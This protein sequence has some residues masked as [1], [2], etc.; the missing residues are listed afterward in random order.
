MPA[1]AGGTAGPFGVAGRLAVSLDFSASF[2]C[3]SS[4]FLAA[5]SASIFFLIFSMAESRS[6][7]VSFFFSSIGFFFSSVTAGAA[8]FSGF[9]GVSFL[10]SA[11]FSTGTVTVSASVTVSAGSAGWSRSVITG[12]ST[13]SCPPSP[14]SSPETRLTE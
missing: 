13:P 10:I 3:S 5:S 11:G 12:G 8:G 7:V 6:S 1:P 9:W 2:F 4:F 14:G